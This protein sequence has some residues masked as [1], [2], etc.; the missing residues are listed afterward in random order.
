VRDDLQSPPVSFPAPSAEDRTVKSRN[1]QH[2]PSDGGDLENWLHE[3]TDGETTAR[4]LRKRL[5]AGGRQIEGHCTVCTGTA[6]GKIYF[7]PDGHLHGR[8]SA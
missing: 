8:H 1:V 7:G 3:L 2:E 5:V 6:T 4:R